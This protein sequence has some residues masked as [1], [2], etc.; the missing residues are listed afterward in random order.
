MDSLGPY[1]FESDEAAIKNFVRELVTQSVVPVMERLCATWNDQV[2]SR[3]RGIGGRFLSMSK[4]WSP[5]GSSSRNSSAGPGATSSS[6]SNYDSLQGFYRPD[7]P[8]AI[9]RKLADYAFMLRDFKLAQSIYD[10]LRTDYSNDKAWKY[11]AGANEMSAI[12]LLI[13][14]Q[15]LPLRSKADTIDQ[16]LDTACYSYITRCSVPYYALRTLALGVELLA[17][18]GG[19]GADDAARWVSRVSELDLVGMVGHALFAQ[20][21]GASFAARKGTGSH[22]W[23]SRNRKS[24]LWNVLATQDW[25]RMERN[26][27]AERCRSSFHSLWPPTT[28]VANVLLT[29]SS[30]MTDVFKM[31]HLNPKDTSALPF[32]G[33]KVLLEDL[34]DD[35]TER[36]GTIE[37]FAGLEE[38]GMT[39]E[40]PP[41]APPK[42][43]SEEKV[44]IKKHRR[45]VSVMGVNTET[46]A[47]E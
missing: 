19:S 29:P 8:E 27:Q 18:R 38:P 22:G 12:S 1:L 30:G 6:G 36:K 23:G 45:G 32:E 24:A 11:Y 15:H 39:F 47:G 3:R 20:R 17:L 7:A 40:I 43:P 35:V 10:L 25:V 13:G 46:F 34:R 9:L 44:D 5:F 31:Y 16:M 41:D 14:F 33:M 2:A 42:R 26:K 28:V 21:V 4:K 37:A